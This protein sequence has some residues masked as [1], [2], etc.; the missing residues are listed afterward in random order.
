MDNLGFTRGLETARR[1]HLAGRSRRLPAV[2]TALAIM[3]GLTSVALL[4]SAIVTGQSAGELVASGMNPGTGDFQ[5]LAL[6]GA[7]PRQSVVVAVGTLDVSGAG[8]SR[9]GGS[10]CMGLKGNHTSRCVRSIRAWPNFLGVADM[11]P[12]DRVSSTFTVAVSGAKARYVALDAKHL[13]TKTCS[14]DRLVCPRG[15]GRGNLARRLKLRLYDTTT[16]LVI[17]AGSLA[18]LPRLAAFRMI[19]GAGSTAV[20]GSRCTHQWAAGETH[21]IRLTVALPLGG[22][23]DNAYQGTGASIRLTWSRN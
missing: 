23:N 3:S 1:C 6:T 2:V 16:H 17:F 19:C 11:A 22:R 15:S 9:S 13:V 18:R 7:N 14:Q 20:A 4:S 21:T 12:G 10:R 5:A 8:Y